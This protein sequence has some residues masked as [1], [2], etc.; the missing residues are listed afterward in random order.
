MAT[1]RRPPLLQVPRISGEKRDKGTE[2]FRWGRQTAGM[3][4]NLE[5][6]GG[7]ENPKLLST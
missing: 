6:K 2:A 7:V 1:R 4:L 3:G 5:V